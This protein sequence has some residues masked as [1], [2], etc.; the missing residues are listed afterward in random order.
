MLKSKLLLIIFNLNI[1]ILNIIDM[2]QESSLR[3][4]NFLQKI[5]MS[6]MA[7]LVLIT[8]VGAN[9]QSLLWQSSNWLVSA[10]L[11]A[12]V[13]DLTNVE[14]SDNSAKPLIR[15]ATLDAAAQL[16]A[17]DMADKEY[18]A[19]Y[20]PTG[21]SPWHWFNQVGYTYAHAGENLAIHFTDSSEVVEA[22]MN[23]PLH[24]Q[25]IVNELYTEIG[26]GTAKGKYEGYDTV[27]VVQLFGA[28]ALPPKQEPIVTE[29]PPPTPLV[30]TNITEAENTS[31]SDAGVGGTV[32]NELVSLDQPR[33]ELTGNYE[34]NE[35]LPTLA[36]PEVI[37]GDQDNEEVMSTES[38]TYQAKV[39][40]KDVLIIESLAVSTSSGL[41]VTQ[42]DTMVYPHAG[43]T[44]VSM[45]TR[46]NDLLQIIYI[47]LSSVIV[48]LLSA[49]VV[50]AAR[51]L[52]FQQVV[53]GVLLL[54]G[55]GGLWFFHALLT[56]GAVVV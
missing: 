16:K 6:L 48:L 12:V 46:P 33:S 32:G 14:R 49:S 55:M 44:I 35:E 22:W 23:S 34:H 45:A 5:S 29:V 20:S 53:Y 7:V 28:P 47:T 52:R 4:F 24:R 50:F 27:Y 37:S 25:N 41:A 3:S 40:S 42:V 8:F 9:L 18:F 39:G 2:D 21:V 30:V 31:S 38:S 56:V 54:F 36:E 11:P 10:V 1:N 26:V 15:S 13:V 17:Q 19:H 51:R 43:A